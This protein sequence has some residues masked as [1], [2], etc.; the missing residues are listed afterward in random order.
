MRLQ[1]FTNKDKN[2]SGQREGKNGREPQ[3]VK[4]AIGTEYQHIRHCHIKNYL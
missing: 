3:Q 2:Q 1:T 4:V